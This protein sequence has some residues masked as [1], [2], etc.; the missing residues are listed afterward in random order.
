MISA[1]TVSFYAESWSNRESK[2]APDTDGG[3]FVSAV[4]H[5]VWE[6]CCPAWDAHFEF[7][8]ERVTTTAGE[9]ATTNDERDQLMVD[10]SRAHGLSVITRDG[11]A[12]RRACRSGV[13]AFKPEVFAAGVLSRDDARDRFLARLETGLAA[14][15]AR[16]QDVPAAE[17]DQGAAFIYGVYVLMWEP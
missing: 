8:G 7:I 1:R 11:G 6:H 9:R 5:V 17:G 15:R 13:D 14:W 16:H 2:A 12:L 3:A 4:A 10:L